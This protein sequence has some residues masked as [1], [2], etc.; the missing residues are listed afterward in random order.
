MET[1]TLAAHT[2]AATLL[3]NTEETLVVV[4]DDDDDALLSLSFLSSYSLI[5]GRASSSSRIV[6][7]LV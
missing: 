1:D 5:K 6:I 3:V 4:E 2:L 7:L